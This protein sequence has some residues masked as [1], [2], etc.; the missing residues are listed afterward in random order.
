M[1][2]DKTFTEA[3]GVTDASRAFAL[4]DEDREGSW[5]VCSSRSSARAEA[6]SRRW[7]RSALG[8][9]AEVDPS[10]VVCASRREGEAWF[11][12]EQPDRERPPWRRWARWP[13]CRASGPDRFAAVAERWRAM[14]AAAV[15]RSAGGKRRRGG[16]GPV[17]VGG[18]AFAPEG[19]GAPHWAGFEP[20]SLI[21]PEVA[22]TRSAAAR[23]G[24][25]GEQGD[26]RMTQGEVRMTLAAMAGPDDLA[27]ELLA[28]LERRLTES[29]GRS[30]SG[31]HCPCS[32]RAGGALS[33]RERDAAGALRGGRGAR[34]GADRGGEDREGRAGPRGAGPR[35]A[36]V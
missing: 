32:T 35:A 3:S 18:F 11:V 24:A 23:Q 26:A 29:A 33:G 13:T 4:S 19:G 10:A 2:N 34:G 31:R 20:A 21:V 30:P 22:L 25:G 1:V 12:F 36:G 9:P 28:R 8:L 7:R 6:G 14:A 17:A 15:A 5:R 27:E 16:G